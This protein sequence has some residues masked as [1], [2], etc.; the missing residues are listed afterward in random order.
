MDETAKFERE[1]SLVNMQ[2]SHLLQLK[3]TSW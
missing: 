3:I 1:A 2:L